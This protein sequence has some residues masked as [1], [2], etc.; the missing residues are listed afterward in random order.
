[1]LSNIIIIG[2]L[3]PCIIIS[4]W[5]AMNSD[6]VVKQ[7]MVLTRKSGRI[8]DT[9]VFAILLSV[10]C[11]I[12]NLWTLYIV[13]KMV[14]M[15]VLFKFSFWLLEKVIEKNP[16]YLDLKY[17]EEEEASRLKQYDQSL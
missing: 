4:V 16:Q 6:D 1:M 17:R 12:V 11:P 9:L 13:L 7:A 5:M 8:D 14:A 2:Y 3:V 15:E 10:F